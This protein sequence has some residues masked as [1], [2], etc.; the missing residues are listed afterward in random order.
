MKDYLE[1]L[2][3]EQINRA[4][5]L[6]KLICYPLKY[7]ELAGL[8]ERC[9]LILDGRIHF[10][11]DLQKELEN[12]AEDD[13][14]D[15]F[16]DMRT[17]ARE[18]AWVEYYGI[19]SLHYQT[20]EIGFL[21]KLMFKIHGE[22]G[23]PMPPPSVCCIATEH[24]FLDLFTNVIFAP[25]SE[26]EFLLHLSDLYH[27]VGHYVLENRN[28]ELRLKPIRDKYDL[29]FSKVTE[30]YVNLLKDKRREYGPP[31]TSMAIER[32]HSQWK[33]WLI[34]FFCDLFALYTV[35]PAYAWAH[36]HLTAKR[37]DDIHE[38]S[39]L[40]AH[41]HPSDESRMRILI[42][43]LKNLGFIEEADKISSKWTELAQFWGEPK[44]EYQYAY[45][46]ALLS[47]ISE[48]ILHGLKESGISV[49]TPE[50]MTHDDNNNVGI[51]LNKAWQVFWASDCQDFRNWEENRI[52]A[53]RVALK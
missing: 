50:I 8:A 33:S 45:P 31:E 7:S 19:P 1:A 6:K 29:V 21:N 20:E 47:Q 35:G 16:R 39:V 30:H 49:V 13:L 15:I 25:L 53:L 44:T 12:R 37:S 3:V 17:C 40:L 23:L 26:P 38:L 41:K 42:F 51:T 9:T 43:G 32:I 14:R 28:S 36:L 27:E 11:R 24:Y 46:D 52:R 34:E 48:L 4:L 2:I 5:T 22:I 18:I 10:L